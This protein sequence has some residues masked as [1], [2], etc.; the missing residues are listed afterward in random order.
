MIQAGAISSCLYGFPASVCILFGHRNGAD[1]RMSEDVPHLPFQL[2][3]WALLE[4]Y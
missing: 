4:K 1:T 2:Y 3:R